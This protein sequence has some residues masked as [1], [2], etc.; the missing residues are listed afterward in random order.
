MHV[1]L[2]EISLAILYH[3]FDINQVDYVLLIYT[4]MRIKCKIKQYNIKSVDNIIL[5]CSLGTVTFGAVYIIETCSE[6]GGNI[7]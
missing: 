2:F 4:V 7:I 6:L 3:T 5:Y 1:Q